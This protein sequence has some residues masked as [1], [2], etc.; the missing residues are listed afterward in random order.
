MYQNN[1]NVLQAIN[2]APHRSTETY[3][4]SKTLFVFVLLAGEKGADSRSSL[5]EDGDC[6]RNLSF[7]MWM[8]ELRIVD[9]PEGNIKLD[10]LLFTQELLLLFLV[11]DQA[12]L[13]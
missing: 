3:P 2:E 9:G 5:K 8:G 13:S 11:H 12:S 6:E 4:V 1:F 10:Q 7:I